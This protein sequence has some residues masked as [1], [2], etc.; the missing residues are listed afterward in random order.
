MSS[1]ALSAPAQPGPAGRSGSLLSLS[2]VSLRYPGASQASLSEVDLD[3]RAGETLGL[4][5]LNGLSLIH[6]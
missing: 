6:I 2:G 1:D 3:L 5:G 4:L